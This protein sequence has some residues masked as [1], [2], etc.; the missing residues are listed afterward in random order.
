MLI[1]VEIEIND[2]MTWTFLELQG[3]LQFDTKEMQNQKMGDLRFEV[4]SQK[5]RRGEKKCI[6]GI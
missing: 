5:K 4:R 6:N 2:E 3:D 1:P